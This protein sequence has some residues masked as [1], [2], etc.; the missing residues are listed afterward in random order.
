VSRVNLLG[1]DLAA[2]TAYIESLDEKPF[3][4]RQLARWIHQHGAGEFDAMTELAK[5]F[6][7]CAA[8]GSRRTKEIAAPH[9]VSYAS[10]IY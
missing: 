4:A 7:Q 10:K 6:R 1:L 9:T 5:S 8:S 2:L 3:R